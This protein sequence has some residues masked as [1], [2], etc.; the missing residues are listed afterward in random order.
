MKKILA[1]LAMMAVLVSP[2]LA[3]TY[4]NDQ[5]TNNNTTT[6]TTN[7]PNTANTNTDATNTDMNNENLPATASFLPFLTLGGLASL[8]AGLWF[9]RRRRA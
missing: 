6:N 8:G 1:T 3:Q 9:S 4:G 5:N 7:D 2:A